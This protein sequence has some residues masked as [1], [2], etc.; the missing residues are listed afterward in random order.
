M[1]DHLCSILAATALGLTGIV[2]ADDLSLTLDAP[3]RS[4]LQAGDADGYTIDAG[5]GMFISGAANQLTVD[6]AITVFNDQGV[7]I[8]SFD[9][10]ARGP[11]SFHFET[12]AAGAYRVEVAP[13]EAQIGDY[14]I[15]LHRLEPI[16]SAPEARVDQLLAAYDDPATPGAVVAVVRDGEM[17]FARSYGAANLT[18]GIPFE[19]D[20]RTNIGSTSKQFTAYAIMLLVEQGRF[21]LDDDV[22]TLIEELPDLGEVVTVRHLLTHR[23]GYREFLNLLAMTGR[24]IDRGDSIDRSELIRIVQRQT[25][26]Q[27]APGAE[28]N[29]N[30]TAYGLLATIVERVGGKP[31]PAWMEEN[32]FHPLG[33]DDTFVRSTPDLIIPGSAQGYRN[34]DEGF[35]NATDLGGAMGAGGIY[36]TV[37]DLA[38]WVRN[39]RTGELG[40]NGIFAQMT[41]TWSGNGNGYGFGLFIDEH[42][43]LERIHHGGADAAHRSMVMYF[44]TLDAAVITQSNNASFDIRMATR[45]AEVFFEDAMEP[46]AEAAA[47]PGEI[48]AGVAESFDPAAFDPDSFDA[49]AGQFELEEVE[50]F[51]VTFTREG[52]AYFVQGTGQPKVGLTPTS[53]NEFALEGIDAAVTFNVG[54]DGSVDTLTLHQNGDHPATRVEEAPWK[55]TDEQ[56]AAYTGRYFCEELETSYEVAVTKDALVVRVPRFDDTPLT[57]GEEHAFTAGGPIS[58]VTFE[59]DASGA[60]TALR[61]G[62]GR[63]RGLRFVRQ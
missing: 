39:Y 36:T 45:I 53:P 46:P 59:V 44:P 6:V 55:P 60:V 24:R 48:A 16:A 58:N 51:V 28:F 8:A 17:V 26:L 1:N 35:T 19:V 54:A 4:T 5:E 21:A 50:G 14:E 62:S 61:A 40:G 27:N 47:T 3:I 33:M 63:T 32:V 30:N 22:R 37:G 2:A 10:P 23:S 49:F 7:K 18:W 42:R 29:Y 25:E 52:G 13:F 15:A 12:T 41:T 20:T 57:P 31:F 38:K 11:E 34:G 56:M 43:G 9:G